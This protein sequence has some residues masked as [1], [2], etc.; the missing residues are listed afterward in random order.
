MAHDGKTQREA[1]ERP[2]GAGARERTEP[3]MPPLGVSADTAAAPT[4]FP[5]GGLGSLKPGNR[6]GS[7]RENGSNAQSAAAGARPSGA[8]PVRRG[9]RSPP[10]T[11]PPPSAA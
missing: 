2:P 1:A 8:R 10:T 3:T 11:M 9:R 4:P 6:D 7:N 5:M